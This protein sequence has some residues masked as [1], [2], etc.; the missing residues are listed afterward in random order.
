MKR[1]V[2]GAG[3]D[4]LIVERQQIK[5]SVS[6]K[7]GGGRE[8]PAHP[9]RYWQKQPSQPITTSTSGLCSTL[10]HSCPF[11]TKA[12]RTA[13]AGL[14]CCVFPPSCRTPGSKA[15]YPQ[16]TCWFY[17]IH[18]Q[19]FS[20][21]GLYLSSSPR[22]CCECYCSR[23]AVILCRCAQND[24]DAEPPGAVEN[25]PRSLRTRAKCNGAKMATAAKEA[26]VSSVHGASHLTTS[27]ETY[28][29]FHA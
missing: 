19:K 4:T 20:L 12:P 23:V 7:L 14:M 9:L 15:N 25:P 28:L 11:H 8:S 13:Q 3:V 18:P 27:K 16:P 6:N 10:A 5:D 1:L 24:D 26:K 22:V 17:C 21:K 2:I 29:L